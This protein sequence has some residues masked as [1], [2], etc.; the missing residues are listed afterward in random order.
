MS[1]AAARSLVEQILRTRDELSE[2]L[3]DPGL[4]SDRARFADVNKRWS[5]L[6]G[7]FA[8]A[9]VDAFTEAVGRAAAAG[10]TDVLVHWPRHDDWYAGDE[11]VLEAVAGE[12]RSGR[13][14]P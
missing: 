8:L 12:I 5:D 2:A 9:S 7:A 6:S 13:L 10:F 4:P 11:G 1:D 14:S 3:A